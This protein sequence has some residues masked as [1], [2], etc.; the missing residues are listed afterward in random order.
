M[1][2]EIRINKIE[3][4][5]RMITLA[6]ILVISIV[7]FL[8]LKIVYDFATLPQN[9]PQQI[10]VTGE[11]K[12][13]EK[14]DIALVNLGV[15]SEAS[16]SQDAVDENNKIM[17]NI[18]KSVK[19][20]GIDE[21]DIKTTSYNLSPLYDYTEK[22]RFFKGYTLD[23][24]IQVKIRSFEKISDVLDKASSLGANTIG[25]LQFTV[26]NP[27]VARAEARAKAIEQAK[28]KAVSIFA[29]SGLKMGKLMNIYEGGF[30]G[31]GLGCPTPLYGMEGVANKAIS[32]APQVQPGQ[33]EVD[34][35]VTL[36]YW[37]K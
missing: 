37:V 20:L 14:P 5:K 10:S 16:K 26:D 18:I 19:D 31:C 30:G 22:E 1:T 21:K 15:H 23:Q 32:I 25:N 17:N 29:Q 33:M 4:P 7:G 8:I 2:E 34:V 36:I 24:Q 35:S 3:P 28:E 11:G 12:A 6:T 13:Y 27:E 9:Y